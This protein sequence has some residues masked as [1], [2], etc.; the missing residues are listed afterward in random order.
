MT[1]ILSYPYKPKPWLMVMVVVFFAA[2]AAVLGSEALTNDR[3]LTL[4]GILSMGEQGATF[5]YGILAFLSI[6]FVGMGCI[7]IWTSLRS[8]RTVQLTQDALI[9]PKSGIS[10]TIITVPY[11]NITA[12][13]TTSVQK[14]VFLQVHHIG[15]KL[16]ITRQ[17]FPSNETFETFATQLANRLEGPQIA[18]KD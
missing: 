7:G 14:Q 15:G 10:K 12:L 11:S 3:G 9:C 13:E 2:C 16:T 6:G 1:D 17:L 5:F 8:T 18:A 4:N